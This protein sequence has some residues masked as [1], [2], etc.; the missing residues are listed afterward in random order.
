VDFEQIMAAKQPFSV[1]VPVVLDQKWADQLDEA[2]HAVVRARAQAAS[3]GEESAEDE[4]VQ[5]AEADVQA[6]LA[7]QGDAIVTFRLEA[8]GRPRYRRLLDAHQ[9]T[10]AQRQE[11]KKAGLLQPQWNEET[12]P[13]AL[14]AAC[15]AEPHLTE[16]QVKEIFESDKWTTGEIARLFTGAMQAC[17]STRTVDID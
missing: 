7:G 8:I 14:V 3:R 5:E 6:L 13:P 15:L 1:S 10:V 4:A 9:P 11:A 2:R 16:A 17:A 12:F